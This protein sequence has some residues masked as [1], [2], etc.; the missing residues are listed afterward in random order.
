MSGGGGASFGCAVLQIEV[1]LS[2]AF[3]SR[4]LLGIVPGCGQI[5]VLVGGFGRLIRGGQWGLCVMGKGEVE[6]DPTACK[7]GGGRQSIS[8]CFPPHPVCCIWIILDAD[9]CG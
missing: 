9:P 5:R 3:C 4:L 8:L 7:M 1:M 2:V 6:V